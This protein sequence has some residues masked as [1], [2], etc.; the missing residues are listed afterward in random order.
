MDAALA[1]WER[2]I[3]SLWDEYSE[4]PGRLVPLRRSMEANL[5]ASFAGLTNERRQRGLGIDQY[6]WRSRDDAKVRDLHAGHDDKVF[7]WDDPPERVRG[8]RRLME[9][10]AKV[11]G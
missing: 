2:R 7:D 1:E 6:I 4:R 11:A 8:V 5:I 9:E 3:E 10:L